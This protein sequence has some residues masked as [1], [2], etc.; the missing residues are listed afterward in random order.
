MS[1]MV[2][3]DFFVKMM[4]MRIVSVEALRVLSIGEG[5]SDKA[6]RL[7]VWQFN[8]ET[9]FRW[10]GSGVGLLN[11]LLDAFTLVLRIGYGV[12]MSSLK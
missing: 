7:A 2:A 5:Q 1:A 8:G 10:F 6:S 12:V 3:S 9:S 4:H 11:T